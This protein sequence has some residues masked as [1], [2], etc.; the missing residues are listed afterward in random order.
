MRNGKKQIIFAI[1]L[2]TV[3]AVP[4]IFRDSI[5]GL[6]NDWSD[7]AKA[8]DFD[9][10]SR[11]DILRLENNLDLT[12][13]GQRI[14]RAS[15]PSLLDM[16]D[17]NQA[18]PSLA[19][20][21]ALLGCYDEGSQVIAVY[22][23]ENGELN[24]ILES[25]MAHELLHAA[26]ARLNDG[27]KASLEPILE[28]ALTDQIRQELDF[29]PE[30]QQLGELHSRVGTEVK[31]LSRELEDYYA[32]YFK[33]RQKIVEFYEAY[34]L[35]FDELRA[36]QESLNT[37]MESL[38][39]EIA[40]LQDT[41]AKGLEAYNYQLDI[42]ERSLLHGGSYSS[43][44]NMYNNLNTL[45]TDLAAQVDAINAKIDS[46]NGLVLEYNNLGLDLEELY[47]SI[48]SN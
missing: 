23:I 28:E 6:F 38:R 14:F 20:E 33:N 44:Q 29:Y 35:K 3:L 36:A 48:N 37:R 13:R 11:P 42:Y 24:G 46:Y 40:A 47:E 19:L 26:W 21:I 8:R 25:T 17:F 27:Q 12:D 18:C 43:L 10:E 34:K 15:Q 1:I 39:S 9:I 45:A 41:Y 5:A 7:G 16:D 2:A 4:I 31:S 32:K 22:G 30:E